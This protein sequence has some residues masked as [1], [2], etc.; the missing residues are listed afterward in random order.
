MMQTI[1]VRSD[2][3][4]ARVVVLTGRTAQEAGLGAA[5]ANAVSTA[6]SELARNIIKYAGSGQVSVRKVVDDGGTGVRVVASDRG[7]GIADIAGA[8]YRHRWLVLVCG[9]VGVVAA[10]IAHFTSPQ[11]YESRAELLV[12]YVIKQ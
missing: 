4:V 8:L 10:A 3:D 11:L 2:G 6:A 9:V 5:Q 12:D 1:S 7:P